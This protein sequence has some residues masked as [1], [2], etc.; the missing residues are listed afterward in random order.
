[1]AGL[2]SEVS[3]SK[4]LWVELGLQ[5]ANDSTLERINRGHTSA[6]FED[7][8]KRLGERSIDVCA[9]LIVGLPGEGRADI[10]KSARYVSEQ[11]IWGVKFHQ[12]QVVKG[13][14]L[15]KLYRTGS[16]NTLCLEDYVSLVV[17][18]IER[19]R[20][21]MVVHRLSGHVP[22]RFL[23]APRW[24]VSR[25]VIEERVGELL[26]KRSTRQGASIKHDDKGG[27]FA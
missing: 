8:V 2:L 11:G 5:S 24:G 3:E 27:A 6:D 12:M 1:M 4:E 13:T 17:D 9:H 20:P 21:D 15:E 14:E 18:S 10:I 25:F 19:L 7:A 23:V 26:K 22:E 16:I